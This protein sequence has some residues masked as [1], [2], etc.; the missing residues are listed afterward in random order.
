MGSSLVSVCIPTYNGVE[1]IVEALDS[2]LSQTYSNIEIIIS[3]DKSTDGTLDLVNSYISKS[4]FPIYIYINEIRGIGNNWNNSMKRANGK[5]IKFLFQDDVLLPNCIEKMFEAFKLHPRAGMVASKRDFLIDANVDEDKISD[6]LKI[7]ADLQKHLD[8]T[9]NPDATISK[10]IFKTK[11]FYTAPINFIGEP[12]AVMFKK[13]LVD[14]IGYFRE[15]LN[16]FLDFEYWFRILKN[17]PIIILNEKLIKFRIHEK[18]ATQ[19]NRG[20]MKNDVAVFKK[21]LYDDFFWLLS[22][23]QQKKLF[24]RFNPLGQYLVNYLNV[25]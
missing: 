3:D 5:Y 14:K 24:L 16:Q 10:S 15:D 7:Y 13:S 8:L 2:V 23:Y 12:S 6:W 22:I 25:Q 9:Y 4:Q 20:N 18:Q 19:Q 21:I 17:T 11:Y 1:F